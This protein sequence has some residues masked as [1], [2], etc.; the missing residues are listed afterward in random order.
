MRKAQPEGDAMTSTVSIYEGS[1]FVRAMWTRSNCLF[2]LIQCGQP[3]AGDRPR[4]HDLPKTTIQSPRH[5]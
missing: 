4:V 3:R 5:Q 1:A 2:G